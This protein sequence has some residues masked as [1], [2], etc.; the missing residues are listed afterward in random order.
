VRASIA[1]LSVG[2]ASGLVG[3]VL[4][5]EAS[6]APDMIWLALHDR[7]KLGYPGSFCVVMMM[8]AGRTSLL[9]GTSLRPIYIKV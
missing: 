6:I 7:S 2:F 1:S 5:G 3:I 4:V 8:T 9:N